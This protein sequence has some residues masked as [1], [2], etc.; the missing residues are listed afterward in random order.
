[1][2]HI[3]T[4]VAGTTH[5]YP[6]ATP[7]CA[8]DAADRAHPPPGPAPPPWLTLVGIGEDGAPGL[9]PAA[10]A[11]LAS[12]ALVVGAPRHL[13]L[14]A[15]LL[16]A[17]TLAWPSPMHTAY[18]AILARRG[19][20]VA[21]LASGDPLWFGVG[22][23]LARLVPCGERRCLPALPASTLACARLGWSAQDTPTVSLCGRPAA[24]LH[25][26]L[27]PDRRLLVLSADA[28]T[29]ATI[30]ALLSDH[31]FGASTL[32]VMEALGGPRERIRT[33][34]AHHFALPDV[35]AL[36][37]VALELHA[38]PGARILPLTPGLPESLFEHDGQITRREIRA[39]TLA[40]LAPRRGE[41]LWD[42]GCGSGSVS[43]DW[44]LRDPS[45]QAVALDIRADRAARAARN[46]AALGVPALDVR[47][48]TAPQ[49]LQGVPLPDA[50]FVGGGAASP[51]VLATAWAALP[52]GGRLVA[53]SV[54]IETD[55][56]LAQARATHGGTLLRIAIERLEPLGTMHGYRPAMT[57]TQLA[58]TKP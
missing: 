30:A 42:V 58:A 53:N 19:K 4:A 27:H 33:A 34:T 29:P 20:P 16:H 57:L 22:T 25:P 8:Q 38:A 3:A 55:A 12:A 41:R 47:V 56:L 9:S 11:A 24:T 51:G 48:G 32:H 43:I 15:P 40:A 23:A 44:L 14:A 21:V 54:T 2:P 50:V 1:M 17:E 7:A 18:P 10:R 28:T 45:L 46:A 26:W 52:Q 35:D 37:L 6:C 49:A 31:G 13:A 36:N 5:A 39:I